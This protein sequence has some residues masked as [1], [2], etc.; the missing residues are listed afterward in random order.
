MSM[1]GYRGFD[2]TIQETNTWLHAISEEMGDPRRHVAYHALRGVLFALRDRL[3]VEE[4][5]DLA[6]QLPMLMRG[7]YFE[8]YR[9]AGK[10]E[11]YHRAAF[12]EKVSRE[13]QQADRVN[14]EKAT[15]AVFRVLERH[16]SKG[17]IADVREGLP[18]DL[19]RLWPEAV[20]F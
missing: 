7:L 13:L 4:A 1:T 11:K 8:G 15:R 14:P 3:T 2:R 9:P 10:P 16:I 20:S 17:E 5:F 19:R 6:A 18:E 12:L